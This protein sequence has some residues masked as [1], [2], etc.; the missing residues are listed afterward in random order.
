MFGLRKKKD[1]DFEFKL[2][3][4]EEIDTL[5]LRN[6]VLYN[7]LMELKKKLNT[8][9]QNVDTVHDEYTQIKGLIYT[10]GV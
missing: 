1:A 9:E 4:M 10:K 3:L 7:T 8:L 6:D 5:K 2:R